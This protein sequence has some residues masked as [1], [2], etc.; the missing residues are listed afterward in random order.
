[1]LWTKRMDVMWM[2]YN[3]WQQAGRLCNLR[4]GVKGIARLGGV[5]R[6]EVVLADV[7]GVQRLDVQVPL[8]EGAVVDR[9]HEV[10]RGKA[11]V[12]IFGGKCRNVAVLQALFTCP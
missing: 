6:I 7:A 1:M 10:L 8:G 3:G 4:T 5:D 12:R 11:A 9:V 2:T